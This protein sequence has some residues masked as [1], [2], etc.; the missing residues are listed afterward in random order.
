[1]LI[2]VL[3]FPD[4]LTCGIK[5]VKDAQWIIPFVSYCLI[6]TGATLFLVNLITSSTSILGFSCKNDPVTVPTL[7]S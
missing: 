6:T 2:S 5:T 4:A 7:A 3:S 1:M